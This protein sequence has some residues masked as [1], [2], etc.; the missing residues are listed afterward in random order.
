MLEVRELEILKA[1]LEGDISN[2]K[3]YLSEMKNQTISD[4]GF[5]LIRYAQF[6][7]WLVDSEKLLKKVTLKLSKEQSKE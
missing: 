1:A 2:Q 3:E 5:N 4:G 7:S 6:N